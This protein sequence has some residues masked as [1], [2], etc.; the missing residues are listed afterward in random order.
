MF[1]Y[2]FTFILILLLQQNEFFPLFYMTGLSFAYT[3]ENYY[4]PL[5]FLFSELKIPNL[6]NFFSYSWITADSSLSSFNPIPVYHA[7]FS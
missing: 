7:K 5:G 6:L 3:E 1:P 2:K 4:T